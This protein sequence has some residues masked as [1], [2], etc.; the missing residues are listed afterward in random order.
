MGWLVDIE[1]KGC[2]S[3]IHDHDIDFC[4]TMVEWVGVP[5]SD[6]GYFRHRRAVDIASCV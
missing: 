5:D 3:S 1:R 4:V 2:E 6:R